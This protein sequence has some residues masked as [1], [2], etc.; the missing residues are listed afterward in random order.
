[1]SAGFSI[2]ASDLWNLVGAGR[3]PRRFVIYDALFGYLRFARQ[4]R[5]NWP[6]KAA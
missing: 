4:E 2:L 6:V 5:H 1:M 3:A